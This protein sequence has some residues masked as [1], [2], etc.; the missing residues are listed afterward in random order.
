M[1]ITF[2]A[3]SAAANFSQNVASF[4]WSHAGGTPEGVIVFTFTYA[5]LM[6]LEGNNISS[7]T[8]GGTSLTAV[9][10]GEAELD[11]GQSQSGN[12]YNCKAWFLGSGI[13]TGTQ[14]VVV[15][16]TNNT[17]KIWA[18]AITVNSSQ[19][20][21]T[22]DAGIVLLQ[23]DGTI[24]EQSVTDGSSGTGNS[25]RVAGIIALNTYFGT[26]LDDPPAFDTL[27][28]GANSTYRHGIGGFNSFGGTC[29]MV[30]TETATGTGPRNIGFVG[31]SSERTA[32]HL[33]IKDVSG[34][35]TVVKDM[36][37]RGIIPFKR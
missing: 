3:N 15:N 18:V 19:N 27:Y 30:V 7:V 5:E 4:N 33:A 34:N 26:V 24:S 17:K 23:G 25:L 36:I 8:Y 20:S 22:H 16:R 9:T 31:D 10:S 14:T 29:A 2:D 1:A 11:S 12:G 28:P 35:L 6:D 21:A 13:A 37:G 32:V